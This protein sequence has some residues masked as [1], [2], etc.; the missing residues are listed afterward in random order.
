MRRK[1]GQYRPPGHSQGQIHTHR[2]HKHHDHHQLERSRSTSNI[3]NQSQHRNSSSVRVASPPPRSK[4]AASHVSHS[5]SSSSI[6]SSRKNSYSR[7]HSRPT[8]PMHGIGTL[9]LD[10]VH[11]HPHMNDLAGLDA[12]GMLSEHWD[13]N[14]DEDDEM[15]YGLKHARIRNGYGDEQDHHRKTSI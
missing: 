5:S 3:R 4:S 10:Y 11:S 2:P 7:G 6:N 8:S 1:H 12:E 9:P 13:S 14:S 15:D